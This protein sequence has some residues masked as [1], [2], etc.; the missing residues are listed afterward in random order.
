MSAVQLLKLLQYELP[1]YRRFSEPAWR[2]DRLEEIADQLDELPAKVAVGDTGLFQAFRFI[3]DL[4]R[5]RDGKL[6]HETLSSRHPEMAE[7]FTIWSNPGSSMRSILEALVLG[8]AT[9]EK[10]A[11]VCATSPQVIALY[12]RLFCYIRSLLKY[13]PWVLSSLQGMV[14][15]TR[16]DP[17]EALR[18][19]LASVYL[20]TD[21]VCRFVDPVAQLTPGD[22]TAY[23]NVIRR[24]IGQNA[25]EASF[26]VQPA[27]QNAIKLIRGYMAHEQTENLKPKPVAAVDEVPET[28]PA[29][30]ALGWLGQAVTIANRSGSIPHRNNQ[31]NWEANLGTVWVARFAQTDSDPLV[32]VRGER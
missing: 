24:M 18:L 4:R 21:A 29:R 6:S 3:K 25:L 17:D 15:R 12:E 9:S 20:G 7:A 32:L 11:E 16:G 27:P 30:I 19:K 8:D 14:Q 2:W 28:M 13:R 1:G 10:I 26:A 5:C 31:A 22:E 23:S